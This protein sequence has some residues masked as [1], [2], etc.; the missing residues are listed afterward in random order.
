MGNVLSIIYFL[1][2]AVHLNHK[3]G[4]IVFLDNLTFSSSLLHRRAALP[5]TLPKQAIP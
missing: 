2:D 3:G 4:H 1:V 5:W